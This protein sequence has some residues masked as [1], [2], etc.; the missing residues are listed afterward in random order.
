ML[1]EPIGELK[2]K[3]TGQRVVGVE[4]PTME[5]SVAAS[6]SIRG[7]QVRETLTY[8]GRPRSKGVLH[9]IGNGIMMTADGDMAT[10]TGE[11]IG[12]IDPSGSINWRGAIYFGSSSTGKLAF[13]NNVVGVFEATVDAEGN[14]SDKTWEWK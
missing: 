1:G 7:I 8:L 14:F 2:G 12:G 3:I 4:G 6:G 13:L 9:G 10:Y 5:T 11:G